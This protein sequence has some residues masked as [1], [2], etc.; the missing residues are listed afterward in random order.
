MKISKPRIFRGCGLAV[1]CLSCVSL[2]AGES[3]SGD[4]GDDA[5]PRP[6]P[7][8]IVQQ[9]PE[10]KSHGGRL[11]L[12]LKFR[13]SEDT[14]GLI[15]YCYWSDSG[16]QAPTMRVNPGDELVIHFRNEIPGKAVRQ[17][18]QA[19]GHHSGHC[20]EVDNK[21]VARIDS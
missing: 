11:E 3:R 2:M 12:T 1:L 9:P 13:V 16:L 5:C 10:L 21:F 7:G 19:T 17:P 4:T 20:A 15:R 6:A 18:A 14:H 8:S